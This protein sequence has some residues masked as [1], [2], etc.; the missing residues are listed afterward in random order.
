MSNYADLIA[1]RMGMTASLAARLTSPLDRI[2]L[3]AG[4]AFTELQRS[5]AFESIAHN[6]RDLA[7]LRASGHS[8]IDTVRSALDRVGSITDIISKP[9]GSLAFLDQ[10]IWKQAF[11]AAEAIEAYRFHDLL[12]RYRPPLELLANQLSV[13]QQTRWWRDDLLN[14]FGQASA[15]SQALAG[16]GRVRRDLM[17]VAQAW[18]G[19]TTPIFGQLA[20]YGRFLDGAGLSLP[21]FPRLRELT[22]KE[23]RKRFKARLK[24]NADTP[25]LRK[26]RSINHE[27]ERTLRDIIDIVMSDQYGEDW[28]EQRLELCSR[29]LFGRWR[30]RQGGPLDHADFPHYAEIILHPDHFEAVFQSGFEDEE[31]A[32]SLLDKARQLRAQS[33]HGHAFTA[34]DLRELRLTWRLIETALMELVDAYTW[35]M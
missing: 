31:T 7:L 16:A 21:R 29:G 14:E 8:P 3:D 5:G 11:G 2:R 4:L 27:Y 9:P 25:V 26:A 20:D 13:V 35:E 33:H 22:A 10:R 12:E 6:H 24:A 23:K 32:R 18:S 1:G 30:N 34:E 17:E 15:M 28:A 19:L